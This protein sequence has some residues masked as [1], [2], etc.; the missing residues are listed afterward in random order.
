MVR[1]EA[2]PK[3]IDMLLDVAGQIEGH[4]VCLL[5]DAAAVADPGLFRRFRGEV[6]E[7]VVPL[8]LAPAAHSGRDAAGGGVSA[9]LL[10]ALLSTGQMPSAI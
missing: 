8:P 9:G 7:R 10:P 3:E 6:E 5:G 4:P 2:D 1:G